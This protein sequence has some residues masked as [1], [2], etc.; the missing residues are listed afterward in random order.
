MRFE[1]LGTQAVAQPCLV[2]TFS[3]ARSYEDGGPVLLRGENAL[4]IFGLRGL[5]YVDKQKVAMGTLLAIRGA[6][7]AN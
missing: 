5:S 2:D 4:E 3:A 1:N 7:M 6:E